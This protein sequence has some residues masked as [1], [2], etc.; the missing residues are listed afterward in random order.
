MTYNVFGGTLNLAQPKSGVYCHGKSLRYIRH[1]HCRHSRVIFYDYFFFTYILA[2][3]TSTKTNMSAKIKR[4]MQLT[5]KDSHGQL[6][7]SI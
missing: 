5:A 7:F 4:T 2:W 1:Y 6:P 3:G